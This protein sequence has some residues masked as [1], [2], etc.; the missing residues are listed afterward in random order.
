M[1]RELAEKAKL[2]A[3]ELSL[4]EYTLGGS[5]QRPLHHGEKVLEVV[6][7]WGYWDPEDRKDNI[8]IL[9]KDILYRDIAPRVNIQPT[10]FLAVSK[11]P[12]KAAD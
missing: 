8:L 4:E 1:C 2:A 11:F 7:R 12:Q 6:A 9:K 3:H 10:I 5:L